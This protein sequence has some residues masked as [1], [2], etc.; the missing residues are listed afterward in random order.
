MGALK[1]LEV[2][3]AVES[4]GLSIKGA[5]ERLGIRR[6]P[7]IVGAE[8]FEMTEHEAWWIN[9]LSGDGAGTR[10]FRRSGRR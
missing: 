1:K 3:R 6:A 9:R 8:D 2:L 7:T 4:S 5:L 10:Y